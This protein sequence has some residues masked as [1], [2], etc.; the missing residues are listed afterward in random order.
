MVAITYSEKANDKYYY[1]STRIGKK[2]VLFDEE[3]RKI[4]DEKEIDKYKLSIV[5]KYPV[6]KGDEQITRLIAELGA[7]K[8]TIYYGGKRTVYKIG[9]IEIVKNNDLQETTA[10]LY[11]EEIPLI[12]LKEYIDGYFSIEPYDEDVDNLFLLPMSHVHE[13][14]LFPRGF[15]LPA[16]GYRFGIYTRNGWKAIKT[17][18]AFLRLPNN[19]KISYLL[20]AFTAIPKPI[21]YPHALPGTWTKTRHAIVEYYG[22]YFWRSINK[23]NKKRFIRYFDFIEEIDHGKRKLNKNNF[24]YHKR[25]P[26]GQR[27]LY[28]I[29]SSNS[30]RLYGIVTPEGVFS[31]AV[32]KERIEKEDPI[33]IFE[34]DVQIL[35][36]HLP[37]PVQVPFETSTINPE[38]ERIVIDGVAIRVPPQDINLLY[39]RKWFCSLGICREKYDIIIEY[40]LRAIL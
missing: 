39:P 28:A 40:G 24:Y 31:I 26:T 23:Q 5:G 1:V 14:Y 27:P 16:P 32:K 2:I 11:G 4:I 33:S 20:D 30:W 21:N 12:N 9:P 35:G 10:R 36:V 38:K 22:P 8:Y 7:T 17:Q 6:M 13:N 25:L 3:K 37:F 15:R 34:N 29:E 19:K 18:P